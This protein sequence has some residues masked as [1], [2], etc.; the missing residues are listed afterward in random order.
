M[1]KEESIEGKSLALFGT[2]VAHTSNNACLIRDISNKKSKF[3]EVYSGVSL[4]QSIEWLNSKQ[5]LAVEV[6]PPRIL[7]IDIIAK[8]AIKQFLPSVKSESKLSIIARLNN[9]EF[10]TGDT[11][12]AVHLV[13]VTTNTIKRCVE[14]NDDAITSIVPSIG[15]PR[16]AIGFQSGRIRVY[17]SII[18]QDAV[19]SIWPHKAPI[20]SLAWFPRSNNTLLAAGGEEGGELFVYDLAKKEKL[21]SHQKVDKLITNVIFI[22]APSPEFV[23]TRG[24]SSKIFKGPE[25]EFYQFS[26]GKLQKTA[27]VAANT[28]PRSIFSAVYSKSCSALILRTQPLKEKEAVI[29][30]LNIK[31]PAEVVSSP[32][33]I[34]GEGKGRLFGDYIR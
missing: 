31:R 32:K 30:I 19:D 3:D 26:K 25:L 28:S 7:V 14:P 2:T 17:D 23:I 20:K 21:L 5:I 18:W 29:A 8:E 15:G 13:N 4:L 6:S 11:R 33:K 10:L 1:P 16:V 27:S 24:S 12:G 22:D 34:Q 9:T